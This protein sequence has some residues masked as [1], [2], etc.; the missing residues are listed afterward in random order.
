MGASSRAVSVPMRE[1]Q[2]DS[3]FTSQGWAIGRM[4]FLLESSAWRDGREK[5]FS[6]IQDLEGDHPTMP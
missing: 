2:R 5:V 1:N 4:S 3:S 6:G